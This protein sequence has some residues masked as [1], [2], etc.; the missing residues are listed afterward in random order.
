MCPPGLPPMFFA[1][2][3]EGGPRGLT[4]SAPWVLPPGAKRPEG[5]DKVKKRED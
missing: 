3:E 4:N 2:I 1:P 5:P